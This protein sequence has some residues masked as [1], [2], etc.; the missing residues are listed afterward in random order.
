MTTRLTCR[1]VILTNELP[2]LNNPS[3]ALAGRLILLRMTRSWFGQ[4][5][6]RLTD[7]L[8]KELPGILIWS[9]AGLKRLSDRGHFVQPGKSVDLMQEMEDLASPIGAFVRECCV[10]GATYEVFVRDLFERWK[11]WCDEKGRKEAG[12]EQLFGRDLRAYRPEL[13]LRRPR[14]GDSRQRKYVGIGLLSS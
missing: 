13:E 1:F 14:I 3:G 2:R 6:T 7:Q 10:F 4:E 12:N 11:K 9:I 5:N 8:L